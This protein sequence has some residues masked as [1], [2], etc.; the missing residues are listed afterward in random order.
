[1]K[2]ISLKERSILKYQMNIYIYIYIDTYIYIYIY[3]IYLSAPSA[4]SAPAALS[5]PFLALGASFST[6]ATFSALRLQLAPMP[7][8][9]PRSRTPRRGALQKL[10]R[11][12]KITQVGLAELLRT[13]RDVADEMPDTIIRYRIHDSNHARFK[14]VARV[15]VG[16]GRWQSRTSF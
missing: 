6:Y 2:H 3:D 12:G 13:F 1:M 9:R 16:T 11:K 15:A 4:L 7:A 5:A 14:S 10:L 8:Q